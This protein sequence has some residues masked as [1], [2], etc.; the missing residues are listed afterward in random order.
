VKELTSSVVPAYIFAIFPMGVATQPPRIL[1]PEFNKTYEKMFVLP[2]V[3]NKINFPEV[4]ELLVRSS[5][6]DCRY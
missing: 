5:F 6:H 3:F 4:T 1:N 2:G